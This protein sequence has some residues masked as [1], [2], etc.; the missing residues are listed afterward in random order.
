MR[1]VD[2]KVNQEFLPLLFHSTFTPDYGDLRRKLMSMPIRFG[3]MALS[4]FAS[5]ARADIMRRCSRAMSAPATDAARIHQIAG[6][7]SEDQ[8]SMEYKSAREIRAIMRVEKENK[9]WMPIMEELQQ[10]GDA[11][12]KK[13][14]YENMTVGTNSFLA[15]GYWSKYINEPANNQATKD[16][17]CLRYVLQPDGL[18]PCCPAHPNIP[19]DEDH[20]MNCPSLRQSVRNRVHNEIRDFCY[21]QC[22]RASLPFVKLE[23]HIQ[24]FAQLLRCAGPNNQELVDARGDLMTNG[25]WSETDSR[26]LDFTG[27]NF[28]TSPLVNSGN[29][30]NIRICIQT[31]RF[32]GRRWWIGGTEKRTANT[33]S[34]GTE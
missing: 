24:D 10:C 25:L 21:D 23:P 5:D 17:N 1:Q 27:V 12:L 11:K 13:R 4:A 9:L 18:R 32:V 33:W 3:G 8:S 31:L 15:N 14:M 34:A 30:Q 29:W 6:L 7:V 19:W 2:L 28:V 22:R 16:L 26:I 20:A